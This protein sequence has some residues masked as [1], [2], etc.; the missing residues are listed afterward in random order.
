VIGPRVILMVELAAMVLRVPVVEFMLIV[1]V[2][3]FTVQVVDERA[4]DDTVTMQYERVEGT[5]MIEGYP[6]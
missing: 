6:I 4:T 2:A 1:L 3:V 5:E